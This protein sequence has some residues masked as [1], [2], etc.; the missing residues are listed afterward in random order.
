MKIFDPHIHMSSRTTDDYQRMYDNGIRVV[1][2]PAFWMGQ[3]RTHAGTFE[4]YFL[5]LIGWEPFRASQFG[6]HHL[7][8][9]ALNPKESNN[10]NL[11]REVLELLP[12]YLAKE[13]VV[14]VGE[15]GLDDQTTQEEKV[16]LAQLEMAKEFNLPVL[17]HTPHR[18]KKTGTQRCLDIVKESNI[19]PEFVLIDHNIE[20]TF[21][22][23]LD[24]GHW[25]GYSIYPETKMD[26]FRMANII[27]K[28]GSHKTIINSAA[29]WGVSDP[30]MV[31]KTIIEM[32]KLNITNKVIQEVVWDNPM[33]FFAQSG[34][35][36]KKF[37]DTE[38]KIDQTKLH[39]ENSVLRGQNPLQLI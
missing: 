34:K 9:L 27:K 37:F 6:I 26:E 12:F 5:S 25:A 36:D 20:D 4:D 32:K 39:E 28:F 29:D 21:Q 1:L 38:I 13:N 17:V 30:L 19:N 33:N 3:P 18:G 14:G 15:I 8:T 22:E 16:F 35:I 11:A 7:C 24:R 10:V 23:V 2:E 31:P